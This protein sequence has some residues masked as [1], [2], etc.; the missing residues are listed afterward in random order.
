MGWHWNQKTDTF[1]ITH[2]CGW[3][4]E[5]E[6]DSDGFTYYTICPNCDREITIEKEEEYYG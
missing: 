1:A 5:L 3:E 2:N 4:G 6:A